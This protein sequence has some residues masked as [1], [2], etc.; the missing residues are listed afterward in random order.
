MS[1][2]GNQSAFLKVQVCGSDIWS[3]CLPDAASG[4]MP[5]DLLEVGGRSSVKTR[6]NSD[7]LKVGG[8]LQRVTHCGLVV[9]TVTLSMTE[10]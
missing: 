6:H 10:V 1:K 4:Q 7:L 9:R 2:F 8:T 5:Q 3:G